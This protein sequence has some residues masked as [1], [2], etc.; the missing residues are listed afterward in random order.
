M[1]RYLFY[2][3]HY[4]DNFELGNP[5]L[6]RSPVLFQ[7]VDSY[8]EKLTP[9][10]PDSICLSL[11]RIF[12]LMKPSKETFQFYFVHYL[13]QYAKS[14]LVGFDAIYV[15]LAKKYIETGLTDEFIEK[16]NRDKIID[17]ANKI[18]PT[19]IGKIAPNIKV[20]GENNTEVELH[21]IKAKH[22]IVFFFAPDC[23]H[24]QKQTPDLI[25]FAKKMQ[26]K[27]IDIKI[28]TVCTYIGAEKMPECWKYLKEKGIDAPEMKGV[29][30]NTVDP[31][32]ISRYKTL[33]NVQTTPQ[34]FVLDEN[35]VIRSK[36][37]EAKQLEEVLDFIIK[38][39]TEKLKKGK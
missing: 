12:G 21:K 15:H 19:I 10:H 17:N 34:L 30:T 8:I 7:R 22:T 9:Q 35:K 37:I 11:D 31:F 32:L 3:E 25:E 5:A 26:A 33:Y 38:E 16:E 2:K 1:A 29:F 13:N 14:K 20:F 18:F 39:D 23:G 27:N 36:S 28:L 6:L 4:F 24:C